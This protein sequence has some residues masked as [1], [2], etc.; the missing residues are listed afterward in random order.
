MSD[1]VQ[2][3][4]KKFTWRKWRAGLIVASFLGLFSALA[5]LAGGFKWI[6]F[7]SVL[8][9]SL[10]THWITYLKNHP[11]ESIDE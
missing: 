5:S 10:A 1:V 8:G 4:L 6:V 11:I 3:T 2:N 9:T 7:L